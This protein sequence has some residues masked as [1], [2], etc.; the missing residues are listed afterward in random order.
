MAGG[1]FEPQFI[2]YHATPHTC[3]ESGA[4]NPCETDILS[5]PRCLPS[6]V[7]VRLTRG[8]TR[9]SATHLSLTIIPGCDISRCSY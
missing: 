7:T 3:L 8:T 4:I 2:R 6:T 1:E 5:A 9:H